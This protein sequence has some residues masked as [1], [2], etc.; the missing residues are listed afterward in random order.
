MSWPVDS[1]NGFDQPFDDKALVVNGQLD[2]DVGPVLRWRAPLECS[3]DVLMLFGRLRVIQTIHQNE[4][5][6][7]QAISQKRRQGEK[8]DAQPNVLNE[9]HRQSD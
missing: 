3:F 9:I 1:A 6:A 4:K 8:I 7:I 5:P 2:C